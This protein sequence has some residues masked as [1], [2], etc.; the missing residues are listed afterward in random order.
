VSEAIH[1]RPVLSSVAQDD[2]RAGVAIRLW[3]ERSGRRQADIAREAGVSR[4]CVSLL[5]C[6]HFAVLSVRTVRAIAAAVGIDLPFAP[7]GRGT[8]LGRLIDE[9][10]SSMV[11]LVV[12]RLSAAGWEAMV[13]FSFNDYGDRGSV[14]VLAWHAERR[15]LLV[16]ETKSRLANLQETCRSLDIKARVVPRLAAQSR[17]WRPSVVGVVLVVQESAR[18]RAAVAR[19]EA[20]FAT[21]FPARTL[22]IRRWVRRPEVPLRGLWFLRIANTNCAKRRSSARTRVRVPPA[23]G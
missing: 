22:E 16:V 1:A 3:R 17:G 6:G 21:S 11:D 8:Q 14:D 15:A 7:R 9:E 18:E 10:H 19:R 23:A 4:Q 5:E 20:I 13:E 2:I 12:R